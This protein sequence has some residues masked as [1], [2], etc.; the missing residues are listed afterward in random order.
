MNEEE[1]N[2]YNL[3]QQHELAGKIKIKELKVFS[4]A[5]YKNERDLSD[6]CHEY[7]KF[8]RLKGLD[9]VMLSTTL[10]SPEIYILT[11]ECL[12]K[13]LTTKSPVSKGR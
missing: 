13:H 12:E 9:S 5:D 1:L 2:V 11:F 6:A 4:A 8:E 7:K 3:W 10:K